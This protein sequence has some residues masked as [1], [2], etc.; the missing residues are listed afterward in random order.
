MKH[1]PPLG[2]TVRVRK[3]VASTLYSR[4]GVIEERTVNGAF[5]RHRDGRRYGWAWRELEVC[6]GRT[7][8]GRRKWR[9]LP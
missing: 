9:Q 7:W 1:E 4:V 8:Y 3:G 2:A 5:V 6:T